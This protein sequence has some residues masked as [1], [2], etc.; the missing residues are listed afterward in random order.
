M[1]PSRWRGLA[2]PGQDRPG[3]GGS[4]RISMP[5]RN[6]RRCSWTSRRMTPLLEG[7]DARVLLSW[8]GVGPEL[9][10]FVAPAAALPR[11]IRPAISV[12]PHRSVNRFLGNRLGTGVDRISRQVEL[13]G[14][15][16]NNLVAEQVL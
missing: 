7:L 11:G 10:H 9:G 8:G 2:G 12:D 16:T 3:S 5:G 4:R 15:A 1:M 13:E 6:A 14:G